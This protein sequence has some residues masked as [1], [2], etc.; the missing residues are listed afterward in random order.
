MHYKNQSWYLRKRPVGMLASDDLSLESE[1]IT[2]LDDGHCLVKT[3]YLAMDPA[4]RGWIAEQ[5]SY[6]EPLPL[7]TP[8]LGVTIG[9]VVESRNERI[10]PGLVVAGVGPW[11]RYHVTGPEAISPVA[12]GALGV[13]APM[14]TSSGHELPMY[15]HAMGTSGATAY[16]G[17]VDIAQIQ[18]GDAVLVSA[19]HGSV[20]SLACQIARLKGAGRVVGIAGGADKCREVIDDF[21][22]DDCIDYKHTDDLSA[23]I[24]TALPDGLDIY[25]DNVGGTILEAAIDNLRQSARIAICGMISQYNATGAGTGVRNLWQLLTRQA[26]LEG[27][28]ITSFLGTPAAEKGFAEISDWLKSGRMRAR[29]DERDMFDDIVTAYNLLYSGS[30]R[31]RLLIRVTD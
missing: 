23:A 6:V 15:L 9:E 7:D 11:A 5:G 27:F 25:F 10:E 8:V 2:S 21:A 16:Y 3:R 14:D 22:A 24:A 29:I 30:N 18:A 17:L 20:G 26:R 4:T 12:T 28:L 19:A 31:G 1:D 13:L